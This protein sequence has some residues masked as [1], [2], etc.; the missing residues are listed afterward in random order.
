MCLDLSSIS[1]INTLDD[2][3]KF[4]SLKVFRE[5]QWL[6]NNTTISNQFFIDVHAYRKIL[7]SIFKSFGGNF[8]DIKKLREIMLSY[9]PYNYIN[10]FI[11]QVWVCGES[12]LL[13]L[14]SKTWLV[15]EELLLKI[16]Q[17]IWLNLNLD[18]S[19]YFDGYER[20]WA[21]IEQY[22][23]MWKYSLL[24]VWLRTMKYSV[25][26]IME[27]SL[28]RKIIFDTKNTLILLKKE[29]III[30]NWEQITSKELKSQSYTIDLF[31][32]IFK[33]NFSEISNK[34]L[35]ISSYSK[36]K[37]EF[38]TKIISPLKSLFKNKIGKNIEIDCY[39]NNNDFAIKIDTSE[40]DILFV[41]N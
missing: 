11:D 7:K 16:N 3:S 4:Y 18:Y 37:N 22:K 27:E 5:L 39:G 40:I 41:C 10:I 31:H 17:S 36:N 35:P 14:S 30:Y 2:L 6:Y 24:S 8:I 19:S 25:G 38:M 13:V 1:L 15:D 23:S 28:E 34:D 21:K 12:K 26:N 32:I 29:K 20:F 33:N 9:L